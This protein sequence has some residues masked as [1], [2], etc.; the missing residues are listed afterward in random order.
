MTGTGR[1]T[2]PGGDAIEVNDVAEGRE[3]T[4]E[5]TSS[6]GRRVESGSDA[7]P[8]AG[9]PLFLWIPSWTTVAPMRYILS[10]HDAAAG[11]SLEYRFV[12][13]H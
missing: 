12:L 7:A 11:R 2:D 1:P 8:A 10:V 6:D 9:T 4:Y 5:I 13:S 3:L